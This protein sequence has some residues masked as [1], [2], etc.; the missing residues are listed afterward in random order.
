MDLSCVHTRRD[1]EFCVMTRLIGIKKIVYDIYWTWQR[2]W[3]DD[4]LNLIFGVAP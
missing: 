3:T 1:A 2:L 4:F